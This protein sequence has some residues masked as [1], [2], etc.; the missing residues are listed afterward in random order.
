MKLN[1]IT[2]VL[3]AI[4]LKFGTTKNVFNEIS[5]YVF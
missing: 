4:A 5:S 3:N 2:K 1:L